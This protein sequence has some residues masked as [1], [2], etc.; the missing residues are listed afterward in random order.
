MKTEKHYN[1]LTQR[2]KYGKKKKSCLDN[3]C[4]KDSTWKLQVGGKTRVM[5]TW[6]TCLIVKKCYNMN[7]VIKRDNKNLI[8]ITNLIKYIVTIIFTLLFRIKLSYIISLLILLYLFSKI[9]YQIHNILELNSYPTLSAPWGAV[10][11]F[12]IMTQYQFLSYPFLG[13]FWPHFVFVDAFGIRC[14]L[15]I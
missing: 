13:H 10:C 9:I 2:K 12:G 14:H 6:D 1:Y 7:Y 11:I 15:F 4:L 3:V 5:I 8:W